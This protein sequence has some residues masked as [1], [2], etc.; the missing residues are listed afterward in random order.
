M[1]TTVRRLVSH[2]FKAGIKKSD[3]IEWFLDQCEDDIQSEEDLLM[4]TKKVKGV[5]ERLIHKDAVLI[6]LQAGEGSQ[7]CPLVVHPNFVVD[8]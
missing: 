6:E 1:E 4:M 7:D 8:V 3:V 2:L 5:I